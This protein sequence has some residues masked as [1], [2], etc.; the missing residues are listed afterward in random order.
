MRAITVFEGFLAWRSGKTVIRC[1]SADI[2]ASSMRQL[3]DLEGDEG[4][5]NGDRTNMMIMDGD[6]DVDGLLTEIGFEGDPRT[7]ATVEFPTDF[8]VEDIES[9]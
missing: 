5:T 9:S 4:N 8:S 7:I 2:M 3:L 1:S 6:V